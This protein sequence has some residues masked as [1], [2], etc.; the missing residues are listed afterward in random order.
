[1]TQWLKHWDARP[2]IAQL[3]PGKRNRAEIHLGLHVCLAQ[4]YKANDNDSKLTR[5]LIFV[6]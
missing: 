4:S 6:I 3:K 2:D 1:M 5:L